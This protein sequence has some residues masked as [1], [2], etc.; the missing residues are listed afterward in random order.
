MNLE[1]AL[2]T[3]V[4]D[5]ENNL[6]RYKHGDKNTRSTKNFLLTQF[7]DAHPFQL[8]QSFLGWE[9]EKI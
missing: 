4:D 5:S 1:P 7:V 2:C 9:D 8:T 3:V 6:Q